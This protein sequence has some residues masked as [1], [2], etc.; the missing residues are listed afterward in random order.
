MDDT[1]LHSSGPLNG[2]AFAR[3]AWMPQFAAGELR[4]AQGSPL[5]LAVPLRAS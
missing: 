3:R 2:G 5:A 4:D 1:L